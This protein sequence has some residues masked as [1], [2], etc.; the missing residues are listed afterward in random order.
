VIEGTIRMLT[1]ER[2]DHVDLPYTAG[3][4]AVDVLP[5]SRLKFK[6]A[7]K[8]ANNYAYELVNELG[9]GGADFFGQVSVQRP[10]PDR[11][12]V[13]AYLIDADGKPLMQN[14]I[15]PAGFNGAGAGNGTGGLPGS[16][17]IAAMRFDIAVGLREVRVPV[18]LKNIDVPQPA[19][20]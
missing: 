4:P 16:D 17:K 9:Q 3:G 10:L 1:F 2:I 7:T 8:A 5:T 18:V 12:I 13:N 19:A 6:S 15:H 14:V 20:K 11:A